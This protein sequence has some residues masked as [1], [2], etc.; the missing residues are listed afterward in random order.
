MASASIRPGAAALNAGV[1]LGSAAYPWDGGHLVRWPVQRRNETT[2]RPR[3]DLDPLRANLPSQPNTGESP[4]SYVDSSVAHARVDAR[5]G[6]QML[7][8]ARI[9]G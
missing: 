8:P 2:E 1:S 9:Q 7:A 4:L 3:G 5:S 6:L